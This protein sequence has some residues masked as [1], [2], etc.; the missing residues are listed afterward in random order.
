MDLRV[1]EGLEVLDVPADVLAGTFFPSR[2]ASERPIAMAC[3]RLVTFLPELPLLNVPFLRFFIALA[4]FFAEA[5]E[6]F[7]AIECPPICPSL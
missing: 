4:T 3:L 2:R 5:L 6:Y 1:L 7:R